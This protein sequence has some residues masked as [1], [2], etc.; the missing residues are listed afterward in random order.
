MI[1]FLRGTVDEKQAP[2]VVI[3]VNGVGY[4]V[5]TPMSS[6]FNLPALGET[7]SLR[8]H[9]VV[10]EDAHVLYGFLTEQ[11]RALFRSLIKVNGVGPKVALGILSGVSVSDFCLWV[12]DSN[13]AALVRLPGIGKKTA[14]RLVI[15]MR[16]RLP[17]GTVT[18]TPPPLGV[19]TQKTSAVEEAISALVALGYKP[20]DAEKRARAVASDDASSEQIIRSALQSAAKK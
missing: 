17:E 10:R 12:S 2:H 19:L 13:V 11:E 8:T 6:F 15:D 16:D 20:Q 3:D 18:T 5:E 4:D 14:E 1:G 9:L 7:V